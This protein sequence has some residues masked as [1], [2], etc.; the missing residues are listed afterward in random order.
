MADEIAGKVRGDIFPIDIY[1]RPY[2]MI[3]S[4]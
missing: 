1:M 4:I 3:K 2:W